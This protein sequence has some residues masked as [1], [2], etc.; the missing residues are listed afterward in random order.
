MRRA[1]ELHTPRRLLLEDATMEPMRTPFPPPTHRRPAPPTGPVPVVTPP[2][3]RRRAVV[4]AWTLFAVAL[5][6]VVAGFGGARVLG[7]PADC[8]TA[9]DSAETIMAATADTLDT[10]DRAV[11][12]E[13][14]I[15]LANARVEGR[16]DTIS[17]EVDVYAPAADACRTATQ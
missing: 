10:L 15:E 7:A 5:V 1:P 16:A 13:V 12:G 6:S 3:A 11:A 14:S 9:L 2:A 4:P 17:G 8:V